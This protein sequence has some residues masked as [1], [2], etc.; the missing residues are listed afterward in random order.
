MVLLITAAPIPCR[1]S[2]MLGRVDQV[3]EARLYARVVL[4]TVSPF[5]PPKMI[6]SPPRYAAPKS[7]LATGRRVSWVHVLA[8]GSKR[9]TA[10]WFSEDLMVRPPRAYTSVPSVTAAR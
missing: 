4:Y 5:S 3:L 1:G 2:A 7:L 6:S 8:A 10:A 9:C